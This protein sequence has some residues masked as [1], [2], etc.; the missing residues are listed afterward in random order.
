MA[1]YKIP[2][3]KEHV[4]LNIDENLRG[5]TLSIKQMGELSENLKGNL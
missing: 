1:T 5:E 4:D 2:Y 3:Y